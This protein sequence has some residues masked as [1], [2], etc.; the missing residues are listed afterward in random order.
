MSDHKRV[1]ASSPIRA[2]LS[3]KPALAPAV[4]GAASAWVGLVQRVA[5]SEGLRERDAVRIEVADQLAV[6]KY[7]VLKEFEGNRLLGTSIYRPFS[8]ANHFSLRSKL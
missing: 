7:L 8:V 1:T 3:N 5:L 4:L 2:R 6:M